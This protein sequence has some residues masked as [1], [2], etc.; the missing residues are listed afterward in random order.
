MKHFKFKIRL[1]LADAFVGLRFSQS[2]SMSMHDGVITTLMD[3]QLNIVPFVG[4]QL[5]FL[6]IGQ[7]ENF[8]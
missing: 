7:D 2:S 8:H 5:T 6:E 1:S 4:L 3:V